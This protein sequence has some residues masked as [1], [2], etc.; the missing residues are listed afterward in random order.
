MSQESIIRM[1]ASGA[2]IFKETS[3]NIK[4]LSTEYIRENVLRNEFVTREEYKQLQ[5]LVFKLSEELEKI[6]KVE[7]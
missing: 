7:R 4:A 6:K 1:L 3:S 2:K 5:K